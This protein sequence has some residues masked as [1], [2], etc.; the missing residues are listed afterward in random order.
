MTVSRMGSRSGM[1]SQKRGEE[2]P[3]GVEVGGGM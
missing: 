3:K 2:G 1:G